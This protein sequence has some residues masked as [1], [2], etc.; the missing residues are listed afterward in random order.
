MKL[1]AIRE[2]KI[3]S[4]RGVELG[5]LVI[6]D[7]AWAFRTFHNL[8]IYDRETLQQLINLIDSMSA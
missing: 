5:K 1:T 7:G 2:D 3:E 4:P 8:I 6:S